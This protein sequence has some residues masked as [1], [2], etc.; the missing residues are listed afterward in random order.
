V[1]NLENEAGTNETVQVGRMVGELGLVQGSARMS[2]VRCLSDEVVVYRL[3][4]EA[5]EYLIQNNP[6]SARLMDLICITYLA[7]RVQ[8]VSNRIFE[9]RCLP[10]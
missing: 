9:T 6:S 4:R 7:N 5:F 1:A 8:H 3:S 2:S 10:I